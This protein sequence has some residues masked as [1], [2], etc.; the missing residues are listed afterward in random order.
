VQSIKMGGVFSVAAIVASGIMAWLLLDA[1]L[2]VADEL[3]AERRRQER[4]LHATPPAPG[5]PVGR[6]LATGADWS[7]SKVQNKTK[8]LVLFGLAQGV[9]AENL[10]FWL[11]V[12]GLIDADVGAVE[13][14]GLCLSASDC[15]L[16]PS[17]GHSRLKIIEYTDLLQTYALANAAAKGIAFMYT[18]AGG[19]RTLSIGRDA[20]ALADQIEAATRMT[21]VGG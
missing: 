20:K 18:N 10:E 14:A 19:I 13:L 11:R 6:L 9:G 21:R 12:D 5:S 3:R 15:N 7:W 17:G 1:N 4:T 8:V 16:P 2:R